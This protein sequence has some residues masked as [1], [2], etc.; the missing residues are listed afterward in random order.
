M[1]QSLK[2]RHHVF[3]AEGPAGEVIK[4]YVSHFLPEVTTPKETMPSPPELVEIDGLYQFVRRFYIR[5]LVNKTLVL[6][7]YLED[8]VGKRA[9][10]STELK[11]LYDQHGGPRPKNLW[12]TIAKNVGKGL[13]QRTGNLRDR[14]VEVILTDKGKHYLEYQLRKR[15]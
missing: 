1:E 15:R 6:A 11:R 13:M 5:R 8:Q 9:F 2:I 10:V 12:D 14:K 7:Y 3:E 4:A